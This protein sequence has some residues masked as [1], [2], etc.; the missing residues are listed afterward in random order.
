M[1]KRSWVLSIDSKRLESLFQKASSPSVSKNRDSKVQAQGASVA[2]SAGALA[3]ES[4]AVYPTLSLLLDLLLHCSET[5][6]AASPVPAVL[7]A[8]QWRPNLS[9]AKTEETKEKPLQVKLQGRA[10]SL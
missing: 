7:R 10:P 4:A 5:R 2:G 1:Q 9:A 3:E 6:Q 8:E